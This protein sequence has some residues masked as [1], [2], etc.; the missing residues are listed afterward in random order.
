MKRALVVYGDLQ[1]GKIDREK[2]IRQ[3]GCILTDSRNAIEGYIKN[4]SVLGVKIVTK[5]VRYEE[6]LID[7]NVEFHIYCTGQVRIDGTIAGRSAVAPVEETYPVFYAAQSNVINA[8]VASSDPYYVMGVGA[9][10]DGWNIGYPCSNEHGRTNGLSRYK[11][12]K[13]SSLEILTET[14]FKNANYGMI[15]PLA[16]VLNID[17][18]ATKKW[19][20][21]PPKIGNVFR[22]HD[23]NLYFH[24]ATIFWDFRMDEEIFKNWPYYVDFYMISVNKTINLHYSL[25]DNIKNMR[26]GVGLVN[27]TRN[28]AYCQTCEKTL[29]ENDVSSVD[30]TV[31]IDIK[32]N[33]NFQSGDTVDIYAFLTS[34]YAPNG[35]QS[36][37]GTISG[38]RL[39]EDHVAKRTIK[40]QDLLTY[41]TMVN[42]D[43]TSVN[44][45]TLN[46]KSVTYS[47]SAINGI[48]GVIPAGEIRIV[49]NINGLDEEYSLAVLY[50]ESFTIGRG[51]Y[52]EFK[53]DINNN[54]Y[55]HDGSYMSHEVRVY[56]T[57]GA[58]RLA[59]TQIEVIK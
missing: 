9:R 55:L 56:W 2:L 5:N 22:L 28:A 30:N 20:Y 4:F 32:S 37:A 50:T 49:E 45:L 36:I 43:P 48:G 53:I 38:I 6:I 24:S 1:I 29:A 18:I 17:Q 46:L 14:Q 15:I 35:E 21:D 27:K 10:S 51:E 25:F 40:I 47:A 59:T 11:P 57:A 13:N 33:N 52:L 12:I 7:D 58:K 23:W 26:F 41:N 8:P 42:V 54:Y 44:G 3:G 34:Q 19:E 16:S 39:I 31:R